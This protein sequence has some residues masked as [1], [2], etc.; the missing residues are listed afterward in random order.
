VFRVNTDGTGYTVLKQFTGSDGANP[1][2]PLLLLSKVLYGTT[3]AGGSNG[4]GTVFQIA[5]DGSGYRVLKN[6]TNSPDGANPVA[7]LMSS[8]SQF[9]GTTRYGGSAG[10][11]CVF[12]LNTDGSGY[13][14]ITSFA[15]SDGRSPNSDLTLSGGV[16]YGTTPDGGSFGHGTVFKV[17]T[18]GTG[19]TV[20][21]NFAGGSDGAQPSGTMPLSGSVLY[22]TTQYGG[23]GG[24]G[25][26]FKV[27][28]DG[29]GYAVLKNFTN[30]DGGVPQGGLTLSG[31]VLYGTTAYGGSA[32]L[33]TVF[34]LNTDGTGYTVLKSFASDG[35]LTYAGLVLS[36][37]VLYGTTLRGGASDYGTVFKV[38]TDGTGFT[39]LKS[40]T[41]SDGETEAALTLSGSA[42]YGTT[43]SGG[44]S[45]LGTVFM[46]NT[47]GTGYAVLHNFTDSPDGSLPYAGLTSSGSVLYGTTAVGGRS[48]YG[49]VFKLNTNGTGYAVLKSF[50]GNDAGDGSSPQAALTLSG[51]VLYGTTVYGGSSG[52][53]TVFK[54]NTNGTGYAVLHNFIYSPADGSLPYA[55][56]TLSG[57]VLYGTTAAGGRSGDGTVFKVS[58]TG[59][60]YAVLHSFTNFPDGSV[61]QAGL[62][63]SGSVLYGTTVYGGGGAGTV[64]KLNT[65]GSGYAVLHNFAHPFDN[66]TSGGNFPY[67]GLTLSGSVLYGTTAGGGSAS[68]G[69]VFQINTDGTGYAVL[70]PFA[71]DG[72]YP[73]AGLAVSGSVLYGTT[74]FGGTSAG[75]TVFAVGT[76]GSGFTNLYS[77]TAHHPP[78]FTNSDG[79][80]PF[81]GVTLAGN[82]LYGTAF[83]GGSSNAGTVFAVNTDGTGFT[84]LHNFTGG[85]DGGYPKAGLIPSGNV[86]Y[87]T[88]Q[89]GGSS[90]RGTVFALNT[91][92][93]GFTTLYSFTGGS[94]G[95]APEAGLIL[96]GNT[97]YGTASSGGD[98]REG[99]VFSLS[100]WPQLTITPSGANIILTWPATLDYTSYALQ[101]TTNLASPVVWTTDSPAPVIISGQNTVTTPSTGAQQFY[102]LIH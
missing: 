72:N 63:L 10:Q 86:L 35:R 7:G 30:S 83:A 78:Y 47:D 87:G 29:T 95:S 43:V 39:V 41:G 33:G 27:N 93:T 64:F 15:N 77:F 11:G 18:N 68:L 2:G 75:G 53:G 51:S 9:F 23:T 28:T 88:A 25:T 38:S 36:G 76:D 44:S 81:T 89:Q 6:F 65:S 96:S 62:T 73:E 12:Q 14:V 100:L 8:G 70:K 5:T 54:V 19:Y 45:N 91:D 3:A 85:S 48:G 60:G 56:L 24:A 67:A 57:N 71:T 32:G 94:D 59:A 1:G 34:Q 55:G 22:G 16:L 13:S 80:G 92:G 58:T 98:L 74:V 50:A 4:V 66:D 37:S 102:R 84:T 101:S 49:T 31:G 40:F 79:V 17:N 61:P 20:L 99:T 82:T 52:E 46:V 97:L 21:K 69:T 26:V 90:G 42:L